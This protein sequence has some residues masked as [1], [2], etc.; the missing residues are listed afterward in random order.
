MMKVRKNRRWIWRS[1]AVFGVV[2]LLVLTLPGWIDWQWAKPSLN[3]NLST[4]TGRNVQINGAIYWQ[5]LPYPG[6]RAK[7]VQIHRTTDPSSPLFM[8]L[9]ALDL[10]AAW[11]PLLTGHLQVDSLYLE[12]PDMDLDIVRLPA[13]NVKL[14][15]EAAETD[16]SDDQAG[17]FNTIVVP[18][19]LAAFRNTV[20]LKHIVIKD[21]IM[22]ISGR[23]SAPFELQQVNLRARAQSL[24]GPVSSAVNFNKDGR[25]YSM[26]ILLGAPTDSGVVPFEASSDETDTAA[27]YTATGALEGLFAENDN[28]KRRF[29]IHG[30]VRRDLPDAPGEPL[31]FVIDRRKISWPEFPP[32][33]PAPVPPKS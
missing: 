30:T 26:T 33:S 31:P 12:N 24:A 11:L 17:L 15:D 27:R 21:G 32:L 2:L 19:W 14:P 25:N 4:I 13:L 3:Q 10:R 7:D 16:Q 8:T 23:Q 1:L 28:Q 20:E 18:A 9:K 5:L 22:R 6:V 29:A